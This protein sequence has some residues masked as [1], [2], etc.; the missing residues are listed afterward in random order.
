MSRV[1][2]GS[3]TP[4]GDRNDFPDLLR[5]MPMKASVKDGAFSN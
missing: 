4:Q 5:T 1:S 2:G 3:D